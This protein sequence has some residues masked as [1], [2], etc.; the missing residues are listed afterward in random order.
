GHASMAD[1][2]RR[3]RARFLVV[4]FSSDWLYTDAQ[5]RELVEA[6]PGRSVEHHHVTASFGHDSFLV[7][8]ETMT[9]LVGGYLDR[10]WKLESRASA[11]G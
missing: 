3:V 7:E 2:L 8:V 6:L 1:A 10:L 9:H 5:A 4:S 11:V